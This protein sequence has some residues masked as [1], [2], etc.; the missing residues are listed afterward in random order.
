MFTFTI[1]WSGSILMKDITNHA[2]KAHVHPSGF[3]R[4]C[5]CFETLFCQMQCFDWLT[6]LWG[7]HFFHAWPKRASTHTEDSYFQLPKIIFLDYR[8]RYAFRVNMGL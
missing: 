5:C 8:V 2:L 6:H 4:L 3:A 7:V 1:F